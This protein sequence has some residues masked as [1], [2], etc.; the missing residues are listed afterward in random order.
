MTSS[1]LDRKQWAMPRKSE[2]SPCLDGDCA[3]KN[4]G[5]CVIDEAFTIFCENPLYYSGDYVHM[6]ELPF[7]Y[8]FPVIDRF[9]REGAQGEPFDEQDLGTVLLIL[10]C[11]TRISQLDKRVARE[12]SSLV[13]YLQSI[14]SDVAT[15]DKEFRS[16]TNKLKLISEAVSKI[17]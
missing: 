7:A 8:Y 17:S 10:D 4:I 1:H 2:F 13:E 3:W 12:V 15:C 6:G 5:G 9:S 16:F 14:V 11:N